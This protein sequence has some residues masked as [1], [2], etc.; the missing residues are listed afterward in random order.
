[1]LHGLVKKIRFRSALPVFGRAVN[2]QRLV[3]LETAKPQIFKVG[4]IQRAGKGARANID[5]R[6]NDK[7]GGKQPSNVPLSLDEQ[8]KRLHLTNIKAYIRNGSESTTKDLQNLDAHSK[9][10]GLQDVPNS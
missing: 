1:M 3:M 2:R 10:A 5:K 4:E 7:P 8:A 9:T 6:E